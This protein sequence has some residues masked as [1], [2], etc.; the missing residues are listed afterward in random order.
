MPFIETKISLKL[1]ENQK[2]NLQNQL[3]EAVA[4]A[5]GKPKS[6]VM[7]GLED[8]QDLY[9]GGKKLENGAYLS[10]KLLGNT[11]KP[12][13]NQLTIAFCQILLNE[14][15]TSGQNVYVSYHPVDLW[16]WN[17]QMF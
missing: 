2:E 9:M 8:G 15:G 1:N 5:F 17:G 6:F 14:L 7:A 13:C 16:G 10:I 4:S 12:V 11:T 3:T